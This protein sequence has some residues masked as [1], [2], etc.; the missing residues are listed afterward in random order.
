MSI[1]LV[2]AP[3]ILYGAAMVAHLELTEADRQWAELVHKAAVL[4]V[5]AEDEHGITHEDAVR[6][7]QWHLGVRQALA[8]R[9]EAYQ[10][11][12]RTEEHRDNDGPHT[13]V[14]ELD[15]WGV[16]KLVQTREDRL[17]I[18]E[19]LEVTHV[20]SAQGVRA[21]YGPDGEHLLDQISWDDPQIDNLLR[22]M[23]NTTPVA[24]ST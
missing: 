19:V 8:R 16:L 20:A 14:W 21:A 6:F 12:I 13:D 17:G 2:Y 22:I 7:G 5:D 11:M 9:T 3:N 10:T 18:P 15:G 23:R 4:A 1:V 24:V